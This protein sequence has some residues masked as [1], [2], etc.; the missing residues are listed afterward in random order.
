MTWII[1]KDGFFLL[2]CTQKLPLV[3]YAVPT[4]P[5]HQDQ[6]RPEIWWVKNH[7]PLLTVLGALKKHTDR[8]DDIQYDR[9]CPGF[10][11]SNL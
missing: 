1:T 3:G 8:H 10:Q 9:R 7:Y 6:T 11:D 4:F 5:F 2:P